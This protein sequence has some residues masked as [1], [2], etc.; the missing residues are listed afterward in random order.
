MLLPSS[1]QR[2]DDFVG[3]ETPTVPL[4]W[5]VAGPNS[6]MAPRASAATVVAN[7]LKVVLPLL[8]YPSR[9]PERP[10]HVGVVFLAPGR[11]DPASAHCTGTG[12]RAGSRMAP[13]PAM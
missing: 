9:S 13:P 6:P 12:C 5:A 2:A 8:T 3:M 10:V 4:S 11:P 7:V 1:I